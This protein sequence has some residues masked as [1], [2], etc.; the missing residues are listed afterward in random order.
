[1]DKGV[2]LVMPTQH[3]SIYQKATP[4]AW[5][6][7]FTQPAAGDWEVVAKAFYPAVPD[8]NYQQVQFIAW[9]DE[10]NY[11]SINCQDNR[12][13]TEPFY[14]RAGTA[15]NQNAN[16]VNNAISVAEDG[17]IL[18][19]DQPA[20]IQKLSEG[21]KELLETEVDVPIDTPIIFRDGEGIQV[22]GDEIGILEGLA[23]F[24]E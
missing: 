13:R 9:Q 12:R 7:M 10:D 11:V 19:A 17:S 6:N 18:F 15:V 8:G 23:E 22:S 4:G 20:G 21:R 3:N 16:A 1:V 24:K 2:G 5:S 14:E